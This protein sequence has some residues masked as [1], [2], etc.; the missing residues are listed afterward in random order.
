MNQAGEEK[1][2]RICLD[3]PDPEL[4]RLF[5]PCQCSGSIRYVHVKCLQQ[6]R[7]VSQSQSAFYQCPQCH[8]RY[9]FS[10]TSAFGIASNH[11]FIVSLSVFLFTWIVY[12]ASFLATYFMDDLDAPPNSAAGFSFFY[13]YWISP[14]EVAGNLIRLALRVIRDED[15]VFEEKLL[16]PNQPLPA[17]FHPRPRGFFANFFRRVVIGIPVVGVASLVQFLLSMSMLGPFHFLTQLRGRNRRDS[18][19]D[20][21]TILVLLAIIYGA[22]R[23]LRGVYRITE[24][25]AVY[26]LSQAE[27]AILEVR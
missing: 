5:S 2:C 7:K 22:Y 10:R 21:A 17:D 9:R 26:I 18:S 25:A 12:L 24:K 19:R 8:Y 27:D 20:I 14:T 13:G 11:L 3:G 6:W 15:I 23:A 16:K 4:G 1:Q